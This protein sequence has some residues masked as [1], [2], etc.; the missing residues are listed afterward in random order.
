MP[1]EAE[2]KRFA[3]QKKRGSRTLAATL[4]LLA[5]ILPGGGRG[6]TL[7]PTEPEKQRTTSFVAAPAVSSS[8]GFGNGIGGVGLLF[9]RPDASDTASPNSSLTLVGLYSDTDSYFAGAFCPLFLQQDLWR[10]TPGLVR[11]R[12]RS[13]LHVGLAQAARF[14]DDFTGGFLK[15]LRQVRGSWYAGG[16]LSVMDHRYAARNP[17]AE[18]YFTRYDVEDVT[19]GIVSA[20]VALDTRDDQRYPTRGQSA[21]LTVGFAPEGW[22]DEEAYT[23]AT[24]TWAGYHGFHPR[25]VL[26]VQLMGRTVSEDAP[27]YEK[28][29]LGQRGDLRGYT[30]GEIVGDH[31]LSS[32][33]E[34]RSFFTKRLGG[35][36]F[37][38]LGALWENSLGSDD[39]YPSCG[40]GLRFRLQEENKVSFRIDYALGEDDQ[41]G[42]YMG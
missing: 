32:Q 42:W 27:Y 11:G 24:A 36:V 22:A 19:S 15:V 7:A 38:G 23:T 21:E 13:D 31:S 14:D 8:P 2:M 16:A 39:L 1:D 5:A 10:V 28:P 25:H 20:V 35:A 29:T 37:A 40:V 33:V 34:L 30:P 18:D 12:V 17:A 41:D 4:C 6:E 26:A 3:T 9:F